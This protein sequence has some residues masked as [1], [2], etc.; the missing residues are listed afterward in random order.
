MRW[1][2]RWSAISTTSVPASWHDSMTMGDEGLSLALTYDQHFEQA[3]F[4]A[5]MRT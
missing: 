2:W 4:R 1:H 5:L 3:G